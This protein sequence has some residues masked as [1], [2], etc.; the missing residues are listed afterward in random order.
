[1]GGDVTLQGAQIVNAGVDGLTQIA[2]VG[3]VHL[4]TLVTG[5]QR[6][7]TVDARNHHR[8]GT[9][10]HVGT[11]VQG[12][13]NVVLQ[14][15]QDMA[16][17]AAQLQAGNA[18]V[19]QAGGDIDSRAVVDS[20]TYD[21]AQAT[22]RHSRAVQAG[23]EA[24]RG[25]SF[26]AGGDLGLQA[27]NDLTLQAATAVSDAG[28][29]ALSAGRDIALAT[30]S[31]THS[32]QVDETKKK[33][34]VLSSKTT[35][36]HDAY[37]DSYAI[38]T[39][40][41]GETVQIAAG[42]DI[43]TQAAQV[44]GTGDVLL[45]AGRD[46]DIGVGENTHTETHARTVK[47]SG[48]FGSGGIGFTIGKQQLDT[49]ADIEEVTHSG[50]LIGSTEGRVDIVAGGDVGITGSDV[51]S[52]AGIGIVGQNVTIQA[53]ED[54]TSVTETQKFRQSGIN[55]SLKGGAVDTAMAVAGSVQRAGEVQDDRLAALH[56]AR[57][58]QTLF[59]GGGAGMDSLGNLGNQASQGIADARNG[60]SS[61]SSGL[62]LRIGI[63]ASS[64]DSSMD[65]SATTSSG[66]RIASAGDVVIHAT[67]DGEGNG[68]DVTITGS[69][70]EGGNV[71]LAAARDL[72]LQSQRETSEQVERNQASSGE[73]GVTI[74]SEAGI[75]VYV[76]A[77]GA[78]GRGDGSGTTHAETTVDAANTL[79]LVSG[80]DTTLEGAQAKGETVIA[81]IGRD[82]TLTSQQDTS[83][84]E[85]RD[86]SA[87]ID[88]AVGMG[89]S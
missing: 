47:K 55:V 77:S 64:S 6:D 14:A 85:R 15:G 44:V 2:A 39:V 35:T 36:T 9:V 33:S 19:L 22:S 43:T 24:V 42:R 79:T 67:G 73:I 76:S 66:S 1:A 70:V 54:S 52:K 81:D 62:S 63:G 5:E 20:A 74:G 68:G 56:V 41:S 31:E 17:T 34:G 32:L 75:G 48:V 27:G 30:A 37:S 65:Y 26:D 23:S 87:G 7:T 21:S 89:G 83:E 57:A 46:I 13:G 49:T 25:S 78:R 72:L 51:L 29:I 11:T 60:T 59:S 88:V 16:L 18:L 80:R 69:R 4:S 61:G 71:T 50:S 53:A 12:A 3:N 84:Y 82:R 28:G 10:T 8:T 38:G 86:Q 40:I 45:A 58:G